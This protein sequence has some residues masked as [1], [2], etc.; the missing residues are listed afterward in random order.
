MPKYLTLLKHLKQQTHTVI[1]LA[2]HIGFLK[3]VQKLVDILYLEKLI[4]F[5]STGILRV[6]KFFFPPYRIPEQSKCKGCHYQQPQS[7]RG[8]AATPFPPTWSPLTL[9]TAVFLNHKLPQQRRAIIKYMSGLL[10][11]SRA[12]REARKIGSIFR[13]ISN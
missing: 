1:S 5:Y 2:R 13:Y 8:M 9:V 4:G 3:L 11:K 10:T 7:I 6:I 12:H